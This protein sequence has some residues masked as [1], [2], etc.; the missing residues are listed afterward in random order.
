MVS[1]TEK[2]IK[3]NKYFYLSYSYRENGKV[4]L[5]EKMLGRN[6]PSEL[7]SIKESFI[8][9]VVSRRWES[10]IEEIKQKYNVKLRNT[11]KFLNEK[12]IKEF[13]IKFTYNSNRIEGSTLTLRE[14]ALAINEKDIA[15]NKPTRDINEA[16]NH[17]RCYEDMV[18]TNLELSMDLIIKWH[19]ILFSLHYNKEILAGVIRKD[20][21]FIAGSNFVPPPLSL[22][23]I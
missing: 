20:Q 22:I 5:I 16:Q 21:I 18:L 6:I 17:M 23:H 7:N 1:I 19:K 9:E 4:N 15:I 12:N 11:S 3:G 13:G 10:I 14:T 2:K 8:C